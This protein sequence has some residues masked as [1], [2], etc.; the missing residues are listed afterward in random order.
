MKLIRDVASALSF[1]TVLPTGSTGGFPPLYAF[2]LAGLVMGGFLFVLAMLLKGFMGLGEISFL[3]VFLSSVMTGFLHIDGLSDSFDVIFISDRER[4]LQ[5]LK[6]SRVGAFGTSSIVLLLLG[7][8]V[9]FKAILGLGKPW[10]IVPAYAVSRWSPV[11]LSSLFPPARDR[12]LGYSM[13]EASRREGHALILS[14]GLA[15]LISL[16]FG[17]VFLLFLSLFPL[18]YL[19]GLFWERRLGG[20]T[21]DN[22]GCSV[23]LVELFFLFF[24]PVLYGG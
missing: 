24:T 13:S 14:T 5:V 12:G 20:I 15:A 22:L 23:E 11:F 18:L 2:P 8:F 9:S 17:R 7:K 4:A 21:G 19:F 10:L 6:D 3:L 1:L 16:V